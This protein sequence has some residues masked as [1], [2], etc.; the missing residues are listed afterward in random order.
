MLVLGVVAV[1]V[2]VRGSFIGGRTRSAPDEPRWWLN[3]DHLFDGFGAS[4]VLVKDLG[5][6]HAHPSPA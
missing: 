3:P 2:V 6:V 1:G 4:E 5:M